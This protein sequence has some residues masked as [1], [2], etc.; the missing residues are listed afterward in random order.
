[1]ADTKAIFTL[2]DKQIAKLCG[3]ELGDNHFIAN[4]TCGEEDDW[5][6][7]VVIREYSAEPVEDLPF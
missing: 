1:M 2:T 3:I 7:N 6:F 4:I 5:I